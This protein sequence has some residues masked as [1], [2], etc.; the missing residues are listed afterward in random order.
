MRAAAHGFSTLLASCPIPPE[1][2][3]MSL[4]TM[5]TAS[6]SRRMTVRRTIGIRGESSRRSFL[7]GTVAAS[8]AAVTLPA[9]GLFAAGNQRLRVGLVGCGGRGTG[10]AL[11]AARSRSGGDAGR[12]A[13]DVFSDQVASSAELLGRRR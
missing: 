7:G 9:G 3:D 8:C 1:T 2:R 10:A 4:N 13:G 11:Q 5:V 6:P 12:G